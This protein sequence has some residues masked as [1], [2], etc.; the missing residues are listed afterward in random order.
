VA[1]RQATYAG[2][3]AWSSAR[4]LGVSTSPTRVTSTAIS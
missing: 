3:A 1:D 4:R 2:R